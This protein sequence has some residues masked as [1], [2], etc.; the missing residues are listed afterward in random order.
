MKVF[1]T[2]VFKTLHL[3]GIYRNGGFEIGKYYF[4]TLVCFFVSYFKLYLT[5]FNVPR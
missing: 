3:K 4:P 1:F 2:I 5:L